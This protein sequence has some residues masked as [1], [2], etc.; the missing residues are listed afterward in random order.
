[1]KN[2]KKK[3]DH[4]RDSVDDLH[5]SRDKA[6]QRVLALCEKSGDSDE[7]AEELNRALDVLAVAHVKLALNFA[8][9][10]FSS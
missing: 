5:E 1:M 9:G 7:D 3:T 4:D 8:S 2:S 10:S 6:L